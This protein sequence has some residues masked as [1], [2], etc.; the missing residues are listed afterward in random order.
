MA[1]QYKASQPT[2]QIGCLDD[3]RYGGVSRERMLGVSNLGSELTLMVGT[4]NRHMIS[5]L[6][7]MGDPSSPLRYPS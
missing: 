6:G 2:D 4:S 7:V 3:L 5:L 1:L